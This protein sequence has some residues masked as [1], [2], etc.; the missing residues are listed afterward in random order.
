M[1]S[2]IMYSTSYCPYCVRAK[3]LLDSKKVSYQ[4]IRVDE[5]PGKRDEM[6]ARSGRRTVP[7]I[8]INGQH[9]GGCDDLYALEDAGKLNELLQ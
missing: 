3:Q 2:I 7:Q 6:I 8:F 5:E 9:I 4:E 1:A